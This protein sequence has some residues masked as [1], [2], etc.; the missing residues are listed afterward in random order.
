MVSQSQFL[1]SINQSIN[2]SISQPTNLTD[3]DRDLYLLRLENENT[4]QAI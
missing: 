4:S 3:Q 1:Q 2:Q